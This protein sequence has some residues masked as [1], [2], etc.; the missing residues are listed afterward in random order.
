MLGSIYTKAGIRARASVCVL[1]TAF[2]LAPG[3]AVAA[4]SAGQSGSAM[5]DPREFIQNLSSRVFALMQDRSTSEAERRR[6]LRAMLTDNF[7]LQQIGDRLIRRHRTNITPAQYAAYRATLPGFVVGS[8]ADRLEAYQNAELNVVRTLPRGGEG[9]AD[10]FARVIQPG[11]RPIETV[12]A[13]RQVGGRPLITN[14]TVSGINLT[15]VQ[16][17]DFNAKIQRDG[18]DALVAFMRGSQTR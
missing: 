8:Y 15:V 4:Q 13:V 3:G 9:D 18:F 10:V 6:A 1:A 5:R 12:W 2:L 16:E 17:D 11:K 7:A 14:L